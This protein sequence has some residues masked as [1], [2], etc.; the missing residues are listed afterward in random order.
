MEV[1]CFLLH[2]MADTVYISMN[3][4]SFVTDKLSPQDLAEYGGVSFI[5]FHRN[6]NLN[7]V[8]R[9]LLLTSK[10]KVQFH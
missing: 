8:L 10:M 7:F 9:Q 2:A 5:L 4:S 1:V 6:F 3:T